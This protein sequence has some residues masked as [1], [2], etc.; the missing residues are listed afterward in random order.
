MKTTKKY[1]DSVAD[2]IQYQTSY[3]KDINVKGTEALA[4]VEKKQNEIILTL[5]R[6]NTKADKKDTYTKAEVDKLI[7]DLEDR[8]TKWGRLWEIKII[9]MMIFIMIIG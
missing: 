2:T 4:D 1:I 5:K 9:Y 6:D 8:L 7:K 3:V